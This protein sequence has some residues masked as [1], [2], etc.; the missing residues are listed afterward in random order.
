MDPQP[1]RFQLEL[2]RDRQPI[3]GRLSDERGNTTTFTGWLELI[4]LLEKAL[5]QGSQPGRTFRP[6]TDP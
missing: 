3:Q 4:A 2:E 6:E 5:P 1:L